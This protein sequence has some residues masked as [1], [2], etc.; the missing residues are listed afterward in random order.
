MSSLL[1]LKSA[2]DSS[3]ADYIRLRYEDG[4]CYHSVAN[5][6]I[7]VNPYHIIMRNAQVLPNDP[8]LLQKFCNSSKEDANT[9]P[10]VHLYRFAENI[11]RTSACDQ[12]S[13]TVIFRG[14]CGSG[15][16]ELLKSTIQY[17]LCAE[18]GR[19][20]VVLSE[21]QGST[22]PLGS[23]ENPF[24]LPTDSS[25]CGRAVSAAL[26]LYDIMGNS[27]T[28]NNGHASRHLKHIK[29]V[30][31]KD[32]KL[33][34]AQL[35]SLLTDLMRFDANI[36]GDTA[37]KLHNPVNLMVLVASALGER[38]EAFK[39]TK[40]HRDA[41]LPS[42]VKVADLEKQFQHFELKLLAT[43]AINQKDWNRCLRAVA[44]CINLQCVVLSGS[45]AAA[46]S[47]STKV[48]VAF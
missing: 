8:L 39:I 43:Q 38:S 32:G 29:L 28:D 10:A 34:G 7:S 31:G 45:D 9:L 4:Q 19:K 20:D 18:S 12:V 15:K 17:M 23:V 40:V 37:S 35:T 46:V 30:Y 25:R 13:Q 22:E 36:A 14:S 48:S 6:F 5:C 16:T 47:T 42:G 21:L 33:L 27:V 41:F 24:G 1:A 26:T 2:T 3:V 44:A 11:R